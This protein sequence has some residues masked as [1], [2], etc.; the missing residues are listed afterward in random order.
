MTSQ[1]VYKLTIPP[2]TTDKT[3]DLPTT[4]RIVH[5]ASQG[6]NL[7]IWYTHP[8]THTTEPRHLSIRL[9]GQ[10]I[11]TTATHHGTAFLG[12]FVFHLFETTPPDV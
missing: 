11:D 3:V 10:D 4:A 8:D 9:T 1:R 5:F 2:G 6:D 12:P 7:C